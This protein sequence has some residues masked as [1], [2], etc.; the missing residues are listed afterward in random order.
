[1]DPVRGGV[2]RCFRS[3]PIAR[4]WLAL[5]VGLLIL[6]AAP[7]ARAA[8]VGYWPGNGDTI[9]ESVNDN[10]GTL[11]NGATA[12]GTGQVGQ[13]F[14]LDGTNDYVSVPDSSLWTFGG[15]FTID[16][17]VN[18]DTI[19]TGAVGSLPNVFV[20]HDG[21]SG[22]FL[23]WVF[24]ASKADS[25]SPTT[26]NF[27]IN[28]SVGSNMFLGAPFTVA[29]PGAW[30][31]VAVVRDD[32]SYTFY[33]DGT[34]ANVPIVD[35]TIVPDASPALLTIGQAEGAGYF[36]G[37]LDEIRIYDTALS[38]SEIAALAA[39]PEP[40]TLLLAGAGLAGLAARARR[41]RRPA[42]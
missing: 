24:Y 27:H 18:F 25:S 34:P 40:S 17:W 22:E 39:V 21:G 10:H 12:T 7:A 23:K 42:A 28:P 8:L 31:N 1:M 2:P 30:H 13:A 41:R 36:D 29:S 37:R 35:A 3:R 6:G 16:L 11:V 14:S 19:K 4:A 33:V 15:D 20:A 32:N 9:D 38:Q 26:L 5:P